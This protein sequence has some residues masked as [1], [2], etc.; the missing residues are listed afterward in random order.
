M[1][2]ADR[3]MDLRVEYFYDDES[4]HWGFVVP[5]LN[6]V[7]GGADTR[8]EAE[9]QAREAILFT[10]EGEDE[11]VPAGHQV[12]YFRVNLDRAS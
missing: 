12:G 9:D 4:K 1:P 10:L 3:A 7:G 2:N 8:T 5:R 6:I 11:P